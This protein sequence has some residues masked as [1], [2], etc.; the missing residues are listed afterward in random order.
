M[1]TSQTLGFDNIG[2]T[3]DPLGEY[4]DFPLGAYGRYYVNYVIYGASNAV[5]KPTLSFTNCSSDS[6]FKGFSQN[7]ISNSGSTDV[8]LIYS[9]CVFVTSVSLKA[10]ISFTGGILPGAVSSGDLFICEYFP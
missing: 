9:F 1:G 10:R 8:Q 6:L 4:F 7:Y 5:V 3:F 2:I